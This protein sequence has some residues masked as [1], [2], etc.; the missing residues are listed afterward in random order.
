[1]TSF[2]HLLELIEDENNIFLLS[3]YFELFGYRDKHTFSRYVKNKYKNVYEC[4]SFVKK[5]KGKDFYVHSKMFFNILCDHFEYDEGFRKAF[6]DYYYIKFKKSVYKFKRTSKYKQRD[7]L[8]GFIYAEGVF[9][10]YS[11][12]TLS[13]S[14]AVGICPY[15]CYKYANIEYGKWRTR[16]YIEYETGI[17]SFYFDSKRHS[18]RLVFVEMID[19]ICEKLSLSNMQNLL[20]ETYKSVVFELLSKQN[21][22]DCAIEKEHEKERLEDEERLKTAY[23]EASKIYHPDVNKS[24]EAE[25]IMKLINTFYENKDYASIQFLIDKCT[26]PFNKIN[27]RN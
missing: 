27:K 5:R 10:D 14:R 8:H 7:S 1:M 2:K 18:D 19:L 24:K 3:E 6:S 22:L 26:K 25:E 13:F 21:E 23:R 16:S 9:Y 4:R 17:P 15:E 11:L 20:I 12:N